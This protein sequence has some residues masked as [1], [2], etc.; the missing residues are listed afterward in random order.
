M[1]RTTNE[2]SSS[3]EKSAA[4]GLRSEEESCLVPGNVVQS[5]DENH[6][7]KSPEGNLGNNKEKP[8]VE[9]VTP[10]PHQGNRATG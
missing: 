9:P 1:N 7:D 8:E 5:E 3:K 6:V 4:I 10:N 2:K